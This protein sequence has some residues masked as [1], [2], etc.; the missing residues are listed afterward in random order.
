MIAPFPPHTMTNGGQ[1]T[2]QTLWPDEA[3]AQQ[4]NAVARSY[5]ELTLRSF[6]VLL[7][8]AQTNGLKNQFMSKGEPALSRFLSTLVDFDLSNPQ[9]EHCVKFPSLSLRNR[10]SRTIPGISLQDMAALNLAI[11]LCASRTSVGDIPRKMV[12]NTSE[13]FLGL[14]DSRLRSSLS[15]LVRQTVKMGNANEAQLLMELLSK[16][17][18]VTITTVVTSFRVLPNSETSSTGTEDSSSDLTLPLIFE[19]VIDASALGKLVTVALQAPGTITGNINPND[20]LLHRVAIAFDTIALLRSMIKQ[21][22]VVV[23]T[24]ISR[25]ATMTTTVGQAARARQE[26]KEVVLAAVRNASAMKP[27]SLSSVASLKGITNTFSRQPRMEILTD[28]VGNKGKRTEDSY[29]VSNANDIESILKNNSETLSSSV[30]GFPSL[31]RDTMAMLSKEGSDRK[32]K[33]EQ[34]VYRF[35]YQLKTRL[36]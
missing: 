34:A 24:A 1:D 6:A 15:A 36:I 13:S 14:V 29:H 8:S 5:N 2:A 28:V 16:R 26:Q 22:R 9:A 4:S 11:P 33:R 19:A 3:P 27:N 35:E 31:L 21:A 12:N 25:A 18:A 17:T 32:K 20:G 30:E 23:S 7:S 10:C